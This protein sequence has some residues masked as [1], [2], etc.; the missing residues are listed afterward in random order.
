MCT[1][2]WCT[3]CEVGFLAWRLLDGNDLLGDYYSNPP[4]TGYLGEKH[5]L[6]TYSGLVINWTRTV[7][8]TIWKS[9]RWSVVCCTQRCCSLLTCLWLLLIADRK[10]KRVW[11]L[12]LE[13]P[14]QNQRVECCEY[15]KISIQNW[16]WNERLLQF[17]NSKF[18]MQNNPYPFMRNVISKFKGSCKF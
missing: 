13:P 18:K 8:C 12:N 9:C 15:S 11:N 4:L 1:H 14:R 5:S 6:S 3:H 10:W 16:N 17:K 2:G 7:N